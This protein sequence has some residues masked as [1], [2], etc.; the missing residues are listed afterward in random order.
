MDSA[1]GND[2]PRDSGDDSKDQSDE[3]ERDCESEVAIPSNASPRTAKKNKPKEAIKKRKTG[4]PITK[5]KRN[6][7]P[8]GAK[9]RKK[10]VTT[11][12]TKKRNVTQEETNKKKRKMQ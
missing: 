7:K 10:S 4:T 2:N 1:L 5:K 12:V 9:P 3:Y 11:A 6:V 8:K